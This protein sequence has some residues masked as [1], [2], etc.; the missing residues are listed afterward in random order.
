MREQELLSELYL[1]LQ[2]QLREARVQEAIDDA[3]VRVIDYG[4]VME[5]AAFP[6]PL[7]SLVLASVLG[8][9]AGLFAVVGYESAN[10]HVRS[11]KDAERA[12]PGAPVLG[13]IPPVGAGPAIARALNGRIRVGPLPLR[14]AGRVA[15]DGLVARS[16][17][18]HP[19]SEAYRALASTLRGEATA[20]PGVL[21]VTSARPDE[22]KSRLAANLAIALA[23]AGTRTILV[24]ADL[25]AAELT[26]LLGSPANPGW[27]R[28]LREEIPF[29]EVVRDMTSGPNGEHPPLH[30]LPTGPLGPHPAEILGAQATRAFLADLRG[31]Y[32]AVIID[33][34][35]LQAAFD[36]ATL[37]GLADGVILV[38]RSGVTGRE[39]V[40]L[41]A[42]DL[43]RARARLAGVVLTDHGQAPAL[44]YP[45]RA[46]AA[47][48]I[49]V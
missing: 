49:D 26:S 22:G 24:D 23:R 47:D 4:Q 9:M 28:L 7:V 20:E 16:D 42:A 1:L 3:M 38:V 15:T 2:A 40:E 12:A 17:P 34:P 10:P 41:A 14:G 13:V 11:K 43:R 25:R 36:A 5:R 31:R 35:P 27:P 21:V 29:G 39:S 8:L 37:G 6:R 19:A 44:A 18:W 46:P 33:A 30:F 32:E 48:T 45:Y